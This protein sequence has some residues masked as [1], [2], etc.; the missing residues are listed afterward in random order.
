[1]T[2]ARSTNRTRLFEKDNITVLYNSEIAI[3][4]GEDSL[5]GIT[6][7]STSDSSVRRL[8]PDG[9]FVSVGREPA[10]GIVKGALA[11]D[12]GGYIIADESTGTSLPGVFAAGDIRTKSLRQVITAASDGASAAYHAQRYLESLGGE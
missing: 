5:K 7:K 9:L 3:I 10:T 6:V 4:E 1:M 11:L 8:Y 2:P 12:R